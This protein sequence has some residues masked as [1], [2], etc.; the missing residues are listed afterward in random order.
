M[1]FGFI[2]YIIGW[3]LNF[4]GLFLLV[5][6]II[7]MIYNEKS[8]FAFLDEFIQRKA[9]EILFNEDPPM[10]GNENDAGIEI[11]LDNDILMNV[12]EVDFYEG[13][14]EISQDGLVLDGQNHIIDASGFSRVFYITAK[15][16]TLKNIKFKNGKYIENPYDTKLNGGA[17]IECTHS[18]SLKIVNCE[19]DNGYSM[20]SGGAINNNGEELKI[21]DSVF[22]NNESNESGVINNNEGH[23]DLMNCNFIANK[24][25]YGVAIYDRGFSDKVHPTSIVKCS[26]KDNHTKYW[27]RENYHSGRGCIY[28]EVPLNLSESEFIGN[29]A[30]W[31][32]GALSTR[33][34]TNIR[35]TLFESNDAH[36]SGGAIDNNHGILNLSNCIFKNN[37]ASKGSAIEINRGTLISSKCIFENNITGEGR[38]NQ[39]NLISSGECHI[40]ISGTEIRNDIE[41]E[42]AYDDQVMRKLNTDNV[43]NEEELI[44]LA[45]NDKSWMVRRSAVKNSN[46]KDKETLIKVSR[47]EGDSVAREIAVDKL[48][49]ISPDLFLDDEDI[50]KIKDENELMSIAKNAISPESRKTA[51]KHIDDEDILLDIINND[52]DSDV[53]CAAIREIK[54]QSILKDLA[55]N[56]EDLDT[57]GEVISNLNDCRVLK[58]IVFNDPDYYF[59]KIAVQN[60]N[61]SDKEV[62]KK[63]IRDDENVGVRVAAAENPNQDPSILIDIA[64]NGKHSEYVKTHLGVY[65]VR[66]AAISNIEDKDSLIKIINDDLADEDIKEVAKE[67]LRELE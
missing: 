39:I 27:S 25:L 41:E 64:V 49:E 56:L 8:G 48:K 19:F 59:R 17:V 52:I 23:L 26:F 65:L 50:E 6:C 53:K 32:G 14:I 36:S 15:N 24:S 43:S 55:F 60:P 45:L 20:R 37:K 10:E 28:S 16:V 34:E 3:I 47:T 42:E 7:S 63:V 29:A 33:S 54:D 44:N 57:K 62:L 12:N 51:V 18:T 21:I 35:N 58:K 1:N 22:T 67:R 66:S 9:N 5:P 40:E 30:S 31:S 46:L 11:K 38:S 61:L 2:T 4:Q 13:G